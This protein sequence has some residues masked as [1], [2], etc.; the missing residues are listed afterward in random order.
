MWPYTW[1]DLSSMPGKTVQSWFAI[2]NYVSFVVVL[3]L[4][5]LMIK[6]QVIRYCLEVRPKTK[7]CFCFFKPLG[8]FN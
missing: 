4:P 8:T 5:T 2:L 1:A 3:M 6:M 7:R